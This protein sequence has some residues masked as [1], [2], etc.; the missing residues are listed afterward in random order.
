MRPILFTIPAPSPLLALLLWT[1]VAVGVALWLG[2]MHRRRALTNDTWFT[3]ASIVG[4]A[5]LM[6]YLVHAIGQLRVNA[7]GSMLITGFLLGIY[8]AARLGRRRGVPAERLFDMGL[9][10]LVSAIVGARVLYMFLTPDAGAFIDLRDVMKYGLGGLSF[11][12]G[13]LGGVLAGSLYIR[14]AK[15]SYWRVADCLAPGILLGYAVTRIG[16]LLNGCCYGKPAAA[17]LPWAMDFPHSPDGFVHQVH[18]TQIYA[19]LMAFAF[20]GLLLWLARGHGLGRAGR[21]FMTFLMLEGVERFV[22]ELFRHPD[23][24]FHG[25]VTPAMVFS[26]VLVAA[27]MVG[28]FVL[29]RRPAVD[30]APLPMEVDNARTTAVAR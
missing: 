23:P 26:V 9:I 30:D 11:H 25:I 5:A 1:V 14:F 29:P 8:T 4:M 3:A 2:S 12:G 10:I 19:S 17:S 24:N 22:M 28:W 7:Y 13:L 27:G 6:L 18:P 15:M 20:V 16:C 21:L